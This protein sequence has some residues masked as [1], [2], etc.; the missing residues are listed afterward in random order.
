MQFLVRGSCPLAEGSPSLRPPLGGE[1]SLGASFSPNK[2][3]S[4]VNLGPH[5]LTSLNL[6]R[7]LRVLSPETVT[8]GSRASTQEFWE[9]TIHPRTT[10]SLDGDSR[11][12]AAI[13]NNV[14]PK[15]HWTSK[16]TEKYDLC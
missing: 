12:R 14:L 6:D 10:V 3:T 8:V 2:D 16:D 15:S 7:L 1:C 9:G 13:I 5:P 4:P 11:C